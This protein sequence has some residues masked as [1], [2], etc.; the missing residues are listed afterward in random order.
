[1][2]YYSKIGEQL[3]V[4]SDVMPSDCDVVMLTRKPAGS[5]IS[6]ADGTWLA[7][8]TRKEQQLAGTAFTN[9]DDG[10]VY[11]ISGCKYDMFGLASIEHVIASG[12]SVNFV[13]EN[14]TTLNITPTNHDALHTVFDAFRLTFF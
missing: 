13:F 3:F 2:N 4:I 1:M 12:S 11:M 9:P 6:Q 8:L 5:Y 10:F 7:Q 14:G